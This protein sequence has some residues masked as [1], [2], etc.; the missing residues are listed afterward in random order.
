MNEQTRKN[1]RAPKVLPKRLVRRLARVPKRRHHPLVHHVREKYG[2]AK[3]TIFYMKEYGPRSHVSHVIIRESVKILLLASLLSS[4]GGFYLE[5]FKSQLTGLL[6]LLI[7]IPAL[8]DMIGDYAT[9]VSS[10]FT[11]ML[12]KGTIRKKGWWREKPL[13]VLFHTVMIIAVVST[14]YIGSL[15]YVFA[16]TQG[17]AF[18]FAIFLRIVEIALIAAIILTSLVFFVS[19]VLG[20]WIYSKKEDPNN[21]LIPITTSIADFGTLIVLVALVRLF[22]GV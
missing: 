19:V 7:L 8:T 2:I 15:A 17:F 4:A 21:F 13:H 3:R 6:P 12:Y 16:I 9:I 22:F 11:T 20:F 1:L 18:Q 10:K 5:S 14:L